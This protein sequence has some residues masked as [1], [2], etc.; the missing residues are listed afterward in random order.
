MK[1]IP[2]IAAISTLALAMSI[3]A[4]E[5][6]YTIQKGDTLYSISKKY[7]VKIDSL[8]SYNDLSDPSKLY[9]GMTIVI[10]GGYTVKKGDTLYSI[11]R[12]Y[13]TT[14][15]ELTDLNSFEEDYVLK[16]GQFLHIPVEAVELSGN[17]QGDDGNNDDKDSE[18]D[19]EDIKEIETSVDTHQWPHMGNRIE[20]TGKLKGIQIEG[21]P[22]DDIISVAGGTVV[23]ASDYGIYKK[24][25]LVE[26]ANG[27]VYGY[28]GNE[29][30]N[31]RV[32]DYV[33][34]GSVIGVLGGSE[35]K[36]DAFFF[37]YKDGKP[38]DPGKAPRV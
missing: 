29:V 19:D 17:D 4:Q 8:K 32:G 11:A 10:P 5:P 36:A 18:Y 14:V 1:K 34:P 37:V 15:D 27:L 26:G 31:V 20:L 21:L 3:H 22:G 30:T 33:K 9:P 28:G 2:L 12:E 35:T 7:N 6:C 24:L 38:L 25:V 13:N 16:I 23:W